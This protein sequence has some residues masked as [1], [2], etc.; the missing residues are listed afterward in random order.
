MAAGTRTVPRP[1]PPGEAQA[2]PSSAPRALAAVPLLA[3]LVVQ[4]ILSA[5]LLHVFSAA[6]GDESL[7]IYA[8]HQEIYE[9]F[10]GGGSPYY[11]DWFSGSPVIYPVLAAMA[12]HVGGLLLVRVMSMAFMLAATAVLYATTRRLF[13]YWP[14]V[15]AA[16]LFTGLG[17]TQGLGVL[18]TY[19][20]LALA[21]MAVS[22]YCAVRAGDG[23]SR[24]L[25]VIPPALLAANATS[26]ATLLFDPV[27]IGIAALMLHGAGWR[28]MIQRAASLAVATAIALA[29]AVVL[30]GTAYMHGAEFTTFSRSAGA[31]GE[32]Y[33]WPAATPWQ[34]VQLSWTALGL[35]ACLGFAALAVA[36]LLERRRSLL[37]LLALLA[38]AGTLVTLVNMKLSSAISLAKHDDFGVW[39][40]CI[41]AGYAL[42]RGA[43]LAR[44][45]RWKVPVIGVSLAVAVLAGA[46]YADQANITGG[47]TSATLR[48]HARQE[49]DSIAARM[50]TF[51][52]LKPFLQLSHG[53][54]YLLAGTLNAQLIYNEHL[55]V[56]WWQYANDSYF[57]YPV[58]GLGGNAAG[59]S[60][61]VYL[62]GAPAYSAATRAHWF[63]VISMIGN[64]HNANDAAIL[65][66]VKST[67]G[68]VLLTT[69]GGAPTY[70]W[71][72]D[73][74]AWQRADSSWCYVRLPRGRT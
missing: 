51:S 57:K 30:A 39:F 19:D 1:R 7:Y 25:L 40:S 49:Q 48:V 28:R 21:L 22:A 62:Y 53:G 41:A 66:A 50:A 36:L 37:A 58:P 70:I 27:V 56:H 29:L 71:A 73:Y 2:Q 74:S 63:A 55:N 42:G 61:G 13:G 3:I 5:R 9:L 24:W 20:A 6:S 45:W 38:V 8:G 31:A 10:H 34:V 11:E 33:G 17:I 68:Y 23:G 43:E 44:T 47:V 65:A 4:V 60:K 69:Q 18:A 52:D 59:T 35:I 72:P 67:P 46:M 15:T 32:E 12:D 14:G 54:R 26:Y 16:G 64:Y